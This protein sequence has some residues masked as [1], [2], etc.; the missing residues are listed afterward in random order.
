[1]QNKNMSLKISLTA[2]QTGVVIFYY[3]V[4]FIS[5][6]LSSMI[7]VMF[8]NDDCS[9]SLYARYMMLAHWCLSLVFLLV[10]VYVLYLVLS[11][12][13]GRGL[14]ALLVRGILFLSTV[15]MDLQRM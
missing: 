1:M 7:F 5:P 10:A 8:L 2:Q 13:D 9:D 4:L 12:G 6:H 14:V 15:V 11:L 3:T